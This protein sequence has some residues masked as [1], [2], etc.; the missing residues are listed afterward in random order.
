MN[1]IETGYGDK[2]AKLSIAERAKRKE[3]FKRA[4]PAIDVKRGDTIKGKIYNV[5]DDGAFV[6]TEENYIAFVHK[7]EQPHPLKPGMSIEG[8]VTF[9]RPDG[10]INL[11]LRPQKEYARVADAEKILEYLK[12]R[13][14]SMPF[15]DDSPPEIIREKF[16]ISKSAFKRALGKLLKDGTVY[17]NNGWINFKEE[18]DI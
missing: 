14:G 9:V 7:D 16:G 12:K 13:N 3:V 5:T 2:R 10:R 4:K 1:R 11:S 8:R 17:E 15:T 6:E 18:A